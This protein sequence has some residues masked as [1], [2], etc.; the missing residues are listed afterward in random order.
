MQ[1]RYGEEFD[2]GARPQAPHPG[3]QRHMACDGAGP[4]LS[5]SPRED[6][7]MSRPDA[8]WRGSGQ[9]SGLDMGISL[10]LSPESQ[11]PVGRSQFRR[12]DPSYGYSSYDFRNAKRS[13]LIV[14]ASVV[15]MPWGK[16]L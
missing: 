13:A 2:I 14:A 4:E 1:P 3:R 5:V 8:P 16:P 12:D 15:G 9:R 10:T 11:A 6:A 7:A